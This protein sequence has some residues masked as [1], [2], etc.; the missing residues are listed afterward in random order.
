MVSHVDTT[1][2]TMFRQATDAV[3]GRLEDLCTAVQVRLNDKAREILDSVFR[4]YMAVMVGATA[5]SHANRLQRNELDYAKADVKIVLQSA[6]AV[7]RLAGSGGDGAIQEGSPKED[8]EDQRARLQSEHVESAD[9]P[10]QGEER[11]P[12]QGQRRSPMQRASASQDSNHGRSDDS[13]SRSD[14][15]VTLLE[16]LRVR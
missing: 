11:S 3:K 5:G 1:R 12:T 13:N 14:D 2:R 9:S 4:D 8:A 16:G 15:E 7:F 10:A 6:S